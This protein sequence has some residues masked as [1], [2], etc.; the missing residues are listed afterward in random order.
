[1]ARGTHWGELFNFQTRFFSSPS[2]SLERRRSILTQLIGFRSLL[3][4]FEHPTFYNNFSHYFKPKQPNTGNLKLTCSMFNVWFRQGS[5]VVLLSIHAYVLRTCQFSC[6]W[7]TNNV[8]PRFHPFN[9]LPLRDE[10]WRITHCMYY[11]Q[12]NVALLQGPLTSQWYFHRYRNPLGQFIA[13]ETRSQVKWQ[14][15]QSLFCAS[16]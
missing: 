11:L 12:Q 10:V 2:P 14:L 5:V 16:F 1:M 15:N 7:P 8:F 13:P 6:C 3:H 4:C 9:V